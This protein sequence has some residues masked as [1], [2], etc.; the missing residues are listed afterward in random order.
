MPLGDLVDSAQ[1]FHRRN[2][3]GIEMSQR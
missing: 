1:L 2:L 3:I